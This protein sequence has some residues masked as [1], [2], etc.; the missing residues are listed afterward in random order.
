ME[1]LLCSFC[2]I[3]FVEDTMPQCWTAHLAVVFGMCDMRG[4]HANNN[5]LWGVCEADNRLS[6]KNTCVNHNGVDLCDNFCQQWYSNVGSKGDVTCFSKV[7]W[8]HLLTYVKGA[9]KPT[10][11][12]SKSYK[13]PVPLPEK[14]VDKNQHFP[15]HVP[16]Y[17]RFRSHF[18]TVTLRHR[19]GPPQP[20]SGVYG[21]GELMTVQIVVASQIMLRSSSMILPPQTLRSTCAG[22]IWN[23]VVN[24][25]PV[26]PLSY[27]DGNSMQNGQLLFYIL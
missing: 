7:S 27:L 22:S 23:A 13:L 3:P 21:F 9:S 16:F 25:Q 5:H 26:H 12:G 8:G 17:A 10:F 15:E 14:W 11:F 4:I 2:G 6:K 20:T 24:A 1:A 19:N 18:D